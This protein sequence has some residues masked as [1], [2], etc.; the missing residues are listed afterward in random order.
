MKIPELRQGLVL[1]GTNLVSTY[2]PNLQMCFRL[3]HPGHLWTSTQFPRSSFR[4]EAPDLGE[5]A[6]TWLIQSGVAEVLLGK[7]LS[8]EISLISDTSMFLSLL[9]I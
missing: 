6:V 3:S 9:S 8:N 5:M 4:A 2:E 1:Q 7:A